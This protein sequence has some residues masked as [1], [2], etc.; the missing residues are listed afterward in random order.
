MWSKESH[1]QAKERGL[2]QILSH[3]LRRNH[4]YRHLC[5][6]LSSLQSCEVMIFCCLSHRLRW[7]VT[8]FLA[9]THT[10]PIWGREDLWSYNSRTQCSVSLHPT[11]IFL[12][13]VC[14]SFLETGK[15]IDS[16]GLPMPTNLGS[17]GWFPQITWGCYCNTSC[18]QYIL[19]DLDD[20][21]PPFMV[22]L[23]N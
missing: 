5:P 22:T 16:Q 15:C 9:N 13:L 19:V 7:S 10:G 14:D 1:L 6:G 2:G 17:L 4:P 21:R 18:D 23:E 20:L 12:L 11:S 8:A 3:S